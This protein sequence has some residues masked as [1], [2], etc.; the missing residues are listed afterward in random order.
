M[1]EIKSTDMSR[2][3][4]LSEVNQIY[5]MLAP[6]KQRALDVLIN[7]VKVDMMYDLAYEGT[8]WVEMLTAENER[9][10][11]A[12]EDIKTDIPK[13]GLGIIGESLVLECINKHI[14]KENV[15]ADSD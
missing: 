9:L 4:A 10:Y 6:D 3:R 14:G 8:E 1:I 5:G 15:D 11:K 7:S 13:L 12:I 2:E